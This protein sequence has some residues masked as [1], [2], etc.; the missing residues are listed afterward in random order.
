MTGPAL[1]HD[2]L[3]VWCNNGK[4]VMNEDD[5]S[6]LNLSDEDRMFLKMS[7][8]FLKQKEFFNRWKSNSFRFSQFLSLKFADNETNTR[9]TLLNDAL[10][11]KQ[12]KKKAYLFIYFDI[13][14]VGGYGPRKFM[15]WFQIGKIGE[16]IEI[17]EHN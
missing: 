5:L 17:V 3:C 1:S 8:G 11:L 6:D 7:G 4:I 9:E 2:G 14:E 16:D 13:D 12:I 10:V 15:D